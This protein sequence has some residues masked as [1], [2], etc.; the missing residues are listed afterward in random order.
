MMSVDTTGGIYFYCGTIDG[1]VPWTDAS[2][3]Q[4]W[5]ASNFV[6][7][8]VKTPIYD[9]RGKEEQ[10]NIDVNGFE[11]LKYNGKVHD[12]FDNNSDEQKCLYDEIANVLKE[13]LGASRV[14]IFNHIIRARGPTLPTEQC[15][16]SHKN[17]VLYPHAD[18][19]PAAAHSK[20][21]QVLGEEEVMKVSKKRFQ[22]INIWRPLGP[23]PVTNI[24]LSIC[25]YRTIDFNNDVHSINS[26]GSQISIK[27]Y[28]ISKNANDQHKWY[29]LR[30]MTSTEMFIFKIFDSN[31]NVARFGAHTAFVDDN[32]TQSDLQQTSIE[33]RSLII[34]D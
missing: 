5:T 8:P 2:P 7:T 33:L 23:N 30:N 24:P 1:S 14:I 31:E 17:P 4:G 25:D 11:V 20:R 34:Y 3:K 10:F 9:V 19:D 26:V 6:R 15:D 28:V 27:S 32:A 13:R 21:K 18:N 12:P 29:Y 22:I 16:E